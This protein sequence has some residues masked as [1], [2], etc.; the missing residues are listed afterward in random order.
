M[1]IVLVSAFYSEGMG[2][3]ENSLPKSLS[4]LGHEVHLITS[5]LN[6]YGNLSIYDKT[7][8]SFLGPADQGV[9]RF[10]IDGYTVHRLQ[11][12]LKFGYVHYQ[13]LPS[14]IKEISPDIVHSFEIASLQTFILAA[15]K[16]FFKFRLFTETHQHISIVK[17]F[18]N[19][20]N[21][22]FLKKMVYKISRTL[23][24]YLASLL[25]EKCY[26]IAPDCALVANKYYGV[27]NKKIFLQPI[28]TDTDLFR[29]AKTEYELYVRFKMRREL[30]YSDNDIVCIYTGRFS[31]DKNP[32][33]LAKA[34]KQLSSSQLPFYGL[35]IG[36]GSQIKE[37]QDCPNVRVLPF[38]KHQDLADYYRLSDVA[39][40][41]TQESMSMLDAASSGLPLV[42]SNKIGEID[43]INRNGKTYMENNVEDLTKV[44]IFLLNKDRR[45]K[46]GAIGREK[47]ESQYSWVKIARQFM[48]DYLAALK[49][50]GENGN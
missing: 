39:V 44:L 8:K 24:T 20:P 28:G 32:L 45:I 46:F 43:R 26:A 41:P 34:I 7:Y 14:K 40:W 35:F 1:K 42:V 48:T 38:M 9:G 30:G 3:C 37:I 33:L 49:Y 15:I 12:K 29:P 47:M 21:G 11:S 36:D 31:E 23:P 16:P 10:D 6:V 17:P 13:G 18:L 25:V 5:N 50:K 2:Y 22:H 4:A 19:N 27:P